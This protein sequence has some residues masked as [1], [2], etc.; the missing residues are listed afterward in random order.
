[1]G[2]EHHIIH[3]V[4]LTIE[5]PNVKS[6]KPLQERALHLFYHEIL[7]NLEGWLDKQ[8]PGNVTIR[9]D[10]LD[11]DLQPLD[12]SGFD[13]EFSE[14]A[15]SAFREKIEQLMTPI[16]VKNDDHA[17][18]SMTSISAEKRIFELFLYFLETGRRPWWSD[19]TVDVLKEEMLMELTRFMHQ[20]RIDRLIGLFKSE[21]R[22]V[23][24]LVK[25]FPREFVINIIMFLLQGRVKLEQFTFK[26]RLSFLSASG[27]EDDVLRKIILDLH[28]GKLSQEPE[29]IAVVLDSFLKQFTLEERPSFLSAPGVQ[30]AVL[31][32][33]LLQ[34][35]KDSDPVDRK[36]FKAI[37]AAVPSEAQNNKAKE[38]SL[39]KEISAPASE[40]NQGKNK[41]REGEE[42]GIYV[43]HAGLVLL[44]PFM[45]C[46][47]KEFDLLKD[48]SLKNE[49]SRN[50][51]IHLLY[52]LATGEDS[53]AEHLLTFEKFL[54]GAELD[55]PVERFITVEPSMKDESEKL[56][57]A[58]IGHWKALKNTSPDGLR[59]GFLQRSG[60]LL[61]DGFQNRLVVENKSHDLLL[62]F[63]PWG[64]GIVKLPWQKQPLI[65][66]WFT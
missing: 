64:Y 36:S 54:C 29:E 58:A 28:D 35:V 22:A 40:K 7:P 37:S 3:R 42:D 56:L 20:E 24:R 4:N 25:Q 39:L 14:L 59:E 5:A 6:A 53:P 43:D 62:S 1:M 48:G 44:H 34:L 17:D 10:R 19:N 66:D 45:E 9:L 41:S 12:L 11:L 21:K 57:Q 32:L 13:A 15:I 16:S 18:V 27:L 52:F 63:L 23:E 51:A 47:F 50:I 2:N 26:E 33:S 38:P 65:V 30:D 55:E 49:G 60:K 31:L 8:L 61:L 46:F